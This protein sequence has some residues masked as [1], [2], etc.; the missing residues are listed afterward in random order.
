MEVMDDET[1]DFIIIMAENNNMYGMK[2][3]INNFFLEKEDRPIP[4]E[5]PKSCTKQE[6]SSDYELLLR[7]IKVY[8][9]LFI[10]GH[11]L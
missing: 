8:M 2:L 7:Q 1:L 3:F 9:Q 10:L 4:R 11:I 5:R 6:V